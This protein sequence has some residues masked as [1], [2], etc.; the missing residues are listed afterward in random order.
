LDSDLAVAMVFVE[1][2][3]A[4]VDHWVVSRAPKWVAL[5]GD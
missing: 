1:V 5:M 2:A 4:L 3:V